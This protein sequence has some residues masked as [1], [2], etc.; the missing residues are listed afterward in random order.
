M[1][2]FTESG[3]VLSISLEDRLRKGLYKN[4]FD[5]AGQKMVLWV[6]NTISRHEIQILKHVSRSLSLFFSPAHPSV[7]ISAV[8]LK[9]IGSVDQSKVL[10]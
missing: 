8:V 4:C 7:S 1:G 10:F 6:N 5:S 2:Y 9:G 3:T